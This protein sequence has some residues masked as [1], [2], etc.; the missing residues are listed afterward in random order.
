[1]AIRRFCSSMLSA[2]W[3]MFSD[4]NDSSLLDPEGR[5]T[6]TRTL[7]NQNHLLVGLPLDET[8]QVPAVS[9]LA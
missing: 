5:S 6:F 3:M 9:P 8:C 7:T 4:A 2:G 1:M